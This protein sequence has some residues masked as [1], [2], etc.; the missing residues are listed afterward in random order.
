MMIY[1]Q[2]I[3]IIIP[4][5]GRT[6]LTCRLIQHL[7]TLR[8]E[9]EFSTEILVIDSSQEADRNAIFEACRKFH[10]E[11]IEGPSS[12]RKK[13]N[14]GIAKACYSIVLFL[15]SDCDPQENLLKQHWDT[16]HRQ[17]IP[18]IG[19]VLGRLEFTGPETLAWSLVNNSSLVQQFDFTDIGYAKWGPTANLSIRHDVLDKV[20][21]FDEGFPFKLGGDDLDLT[22]RL[23]T[24]GWILLK[25]PDALVYHDRSTWSSL[26]DVLGRALRWGRMEYHLFKKHISLQLMHPL[27]FFGWLILI[28]LFSV[29][30]AVIMQIWQYFVLPV[31]WVILSLLLFSLYISIEKKG[32]L[33]EKWHRFR[34][35]LLNSIPEL[36]YQFGSTY[37]FLKHGDLR[38]FYSRPLLNPNWIIGVWAG[39]AWNT[40]SNLLAFLINYMAIVYWARF[41]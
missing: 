29:I 24:S 21:L 28:S 31:G 22:Y 41:T 39:E 12:V 1:Q 25:C 17:D 16:I 13:R 15:D 30:T 6:Q 3:S 11:W 35:S 27:S 8:R 2:G 19:G 34:D 20:G 37:E 26:K 23:T 14:M 7:D 10:A 36:V 5:E 32:T 40:W 38:F 33:K 9:V 18:N 4:T